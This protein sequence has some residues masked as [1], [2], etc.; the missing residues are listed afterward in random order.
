VLINHA[1]PLSSPGPWDTSKLTSTP[2]PSVALRGYRIA[3]MVNDDTAPLAQSAGAEILLIHEDA[4]STSQADFESWWNEQLNKATSEKLVLVVVN[5]SSRT[6][7]QFSNWLK[8][9]EQVRYSHAK[10]IA[11]AITNNNGEGE[12]LKDTH[13]DSIQKIN[14]YPTPTVALVPNPSDDN[15]NEFFSEGNRNDRSFGDDHDYAEAISESM[16]LPRR[17]EETIDAH[18]DAANEEQN[19]SNHQ[20]R[21]DRNDLDDKPMNKVDRAEF[22]D[23]LDTDNAVKAASQTMKKVEYESSDDEPGIPVERI[24]LPTTE[25]GWLVAAP[26]RRKAYRKERDANFVIDA[27][28]PDTAAETEKISGLIVRQYIKTT[29]QSRIAQKQQGYKRCKLSMMNVCVYWFYF[30]RLIS[31][32]FIIP[33]VRKN[34]VICG[35]TSFN[36]TDTKQKK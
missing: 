8:Q 12:L 20:K 25:D 6:C 4:P 30:P 15:T 21:R 27:E 13:M 26:R 22:T 33:K 7:K 29:G 16:K 5:S 11:R 32:H 19:V 34:S 31:F 17:Q 9:C 36:P 18:A 3:V 10:N 24:P 28:V 23:P 14:M 1:P 35:Y 2:E